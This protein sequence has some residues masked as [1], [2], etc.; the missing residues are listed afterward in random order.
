LASCGNLE[1][2][3][4]ISEFKEKESYRIWTVKKHLTKTDSIFAERTFFKSYDSKKRLININNVQF[5]YYNDEENRIK[6]I[7]SIYKREGKGIAKID[8]ENYE[9]DENGLLKYIIEEREHIDTIKTYTYDSERN[10]IKTKTNYRTVSQEFEN[11]LLKKKVIT[12]GN[13]EPKISEFHY[14]TTNQPIIENWVFSGNHR[15]K[16]RFEYNENDMLLRETDSSFNQGTNPNE[17]VE[18]MTEYKYDT[19]DSIVEIVELGRVLSESNFKIR[20]RILFER[21]TVGNNTYK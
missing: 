18:F 17:L 7:K 2:Y 1:E 19:N 5:Y 4:L 6:N 11:G 12:E 3:N 20:G 10:L 9:Y 13:S 21:K 14:G 16:T 8:T 15:M